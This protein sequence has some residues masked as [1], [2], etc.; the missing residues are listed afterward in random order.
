[1]VTK[2]DEVRQQM[3][4]M[5]VG[6]A[7]H[8]LHRD[9]LFNFVQKS[10]GNCCRCG[11]ALSREDFTIDHLE[12]WMQSDSPKESFF[13]LDNIGFAHRKCNYGLST[14]IYAN[15]G[16]ITRYNKHGCRCDECRKAYSDYRTY[17]PVKRKERY[18]R[19]GT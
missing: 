1:M 6:K 18:K 5:S 14:K 16:T 4:G 17:D 10:G 12:P 7:G 9:I 15:H 19:L 3:L 13:N 8:I 2:T 11:E